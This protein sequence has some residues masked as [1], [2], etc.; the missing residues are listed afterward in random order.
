VPGTE[1]YENSEKYQIRHWDWNRPGH[2]KELVARVN[3]IRRRHPALQ[4]DGTLRFHATDN[5]DL[6]AFSKSVPLGAGNASGADVVYAV[7][8]LDPHHVQHGFVQVSPDLVGPPGAG[9]DAPFTAR[10]LLDGAEYQWRGEWNYVR[11]EP[12]VRQGHV[13][14]FARST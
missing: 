8:N 2:I 6:L 4:Y 9:V 10:D 14:T 11:L 3:A 5:P 1:E 7:V 12:E 13:L